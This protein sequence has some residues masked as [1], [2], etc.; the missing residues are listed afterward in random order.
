GS[1]MFPL[2]AGA[3]SAADFP[4]R[5]ITI[6]VPFGAGTTTDQGA[7]FIAQQITARTKQPVIIENKPGASGQI[8]T[9]YATTRPADGYTFM[10]GT[11][12]THAANLSLFKKLPSDPVADFMPT[13]AVIIG[14]VLLVVAPS[15]PANNVQELLAMIRK[16]PGKLTFG[17]AN[18]SSRAGGEVMRER[19]NV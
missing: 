12:T 16:N 5:M 1:A 6:V 9:Q 18:S 17:S 10:I 13:S 14:G 8:G 15:N 4:N 11:N 19:A 3:Q 7:R 2:A